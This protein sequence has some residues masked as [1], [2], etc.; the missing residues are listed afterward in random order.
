[1]LHVLGT[2]FPKLLR[3]LS[4]TVHKR[5]LQTAK[6]KKAQ[7]WTVLSYLPN[8]W[9]YLK[10][11]L[12][13]SFNEENLETETYLAALSIEKDL[14]HPSAQRRRKPFRTN[15]GLKR[16][17]FA[18]RKLLNPFKWVEFAVSIPLT[19]TYFFF[20]IPLYIYYAVT[21]LVCFPFQLFNLWTTLPYNIVKT[22]VWHIPATLVH[23]AFYT[24]M[25]LATFVLNCVLSPTNTILKPLIRFYSGDRML[26][27]K[28]LTTIA[29]IVVPTALVTLIL[30]ATGGAAFL[31]A[32]VSGV[33]PV[34]QSAVPALLTCIT[35]AHTF[36]AGI[37]G[38]LTSKIILSA[39]SSLTFIVAAERVVSGRMISQFFRRFLD[40]VLFTLSLNS[41]QSAYTYLAGEEEKNILD[42][43]KNSEITTPTRKQSNAMHRLM[44]N[45]SSRS[46]TLAHKELASK[47][48]DRKA[49]AEHHVDPKSYSTFWR[50]LGKCFGYDHNPPETPRCITVLD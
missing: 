15:S 12:L 8:P 47:D 39:I 34:L 5:D 48:K 4:V 6:D 20:S 16:Q 30:L 32:F 43:N 50:A 9:L 2:Q 33:L 40:A 13:S 31:P 28:I 17:Y 29:I 36:L 7:G 25:T 27:I 37:V 10:F 14:S 24:A 38:A 22:L 46:N 18:W 26:S 49:Q 3:N 23:S 42:A 11:L 45:G 1:M 21:T 19:L 44:N 41:E 35:T